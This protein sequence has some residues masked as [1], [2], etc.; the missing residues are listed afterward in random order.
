MIGG[1]YDWFD[2]SYWF[3]VSDWFELCDWIEFKL[4]ILFEV[5]FIGYVWDVVIEDVDFGCVGMVMCE[6]VCYFGVV[7]VL[8]LDDEGWVVLVY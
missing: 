1:D 5:V 3:D 4:V 2:V 6:F 8:A 7:G